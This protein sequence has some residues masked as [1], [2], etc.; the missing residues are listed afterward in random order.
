MKHDLRLIC[1]SEH[2]NNSH[3]QRCDSQHNNVHPTRQQRP[4]PQKMSSLLS[5]WHEP[6]LCLTTIMLMM[7]LLSFGLV[8]LDAIRLQP[9]GRD[10]YYWSGEQFVITCQNNNNIKNVLIGA[11]L[12]LALVLALA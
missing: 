8:C 5:S 2:R 1:A 3:Y 12:A 6:R 4:S 7:S 10:K 11:P 9:E